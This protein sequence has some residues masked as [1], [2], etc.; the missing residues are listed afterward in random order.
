MGQAFDASRNDDSFYLPPGIING[1]DAF[2]RVEKV[3][4][5][6]DGKDFRLLISQRGDPATPEGLSRVEQI[7]TAAEESLKGTPS[8]TPRS[9]SPA[10]RRL[11]K[12]WWT[13]PSSTS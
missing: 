12:I 1:S 13:D 4:M 5:S 3:F 2:K 9:I 11:P 8:K 6:P 10:R 7:K